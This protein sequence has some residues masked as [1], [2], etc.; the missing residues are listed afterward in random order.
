MAQTLKT[1][2]ELFPN[3]DDSFLEGM[4]NK[5]LWFLENLETKDCQRIKSR[6]DSDYK[7]TVMTE[8]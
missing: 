2:K 4:K 1:Y 6:I 5:N 7:K 3:L 8:I